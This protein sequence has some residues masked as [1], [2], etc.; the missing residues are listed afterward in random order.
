MDKE[1]FSTLVNEVL[2]TTAKP[3]KNLFE[4]GYDDWHCR[5]RLAHFLAM[6]EINHLPQAKE[7]FHSIIA[8]EPDESDSQDIEEKAYALQH[9][10][11]LEK[12]EKN[13]NA[14]LEHINLAIETAESYDFLYKYILRGELWGERWNLLHLLKRT[15]EAESEI[16]ERIEVFEDIPIEHNSYLYYGY[17]FKAQLAAEKGTALIAKDFMHMALNNMEIPAEYKKPLDLAFAATHDNISWILA[18]ID[19]ATPNPDNLHWDI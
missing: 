6:P 13:Y 4:A 8:V 7:L 19:K 15:E 18:E 2:S 16:D 5:A 1:E 10:S 12:D 9:L 11:Q 14:A 3:P 17:R